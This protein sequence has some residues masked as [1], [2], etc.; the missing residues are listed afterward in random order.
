MLGKLVEA[1]SPGPHDSLDES[2]LNAAIALVTSMQPNRELEALVAAEIAATGFAGL[3]FLRQ[4]QRHMDEVFVSLYGGIRDEASSP[5]AR[6]DPSLGQASPRQ[7]ADGRGQTRTHLSRGS[8]GGWNCQPIPGKWG[9]CKMSC[10]A[11][12]PIAS[13][14][15]KL[16]AA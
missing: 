2:T 4:S 9:G 14:P 7:S 16:P 6:Y 3:K 11:A 8:R 12:D 10:E 5:A 13:G 1:L 15:A